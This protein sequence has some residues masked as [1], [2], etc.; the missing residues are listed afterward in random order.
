MPSQAPKNAKPGG[1]GWHSWLVFLEG[2]RLAA[3]QAPE[4]ASTRGARLAHSVG[5]LWQPTKREE[6]GRGSVQSVVPT[7]ERRDEQ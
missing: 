2:S 3:S 7:R 4:C 5:T 6:G 1:R